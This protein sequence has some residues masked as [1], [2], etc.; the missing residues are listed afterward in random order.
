[1]EYTRSSARKVLI[2]FSASF[3]LFLTFVSAFLL[4]FLY[5]YYV[6]GNAVVAWMDAPLSILIEVLNAVALFSSVAASVYGIRL[7]GFRDSVP[8]VLLNAAQI[9]LSFLCSLAVS[10]LCT[11]PALFAANFLYLLRVVGLNLLIYAAVLALILL[12]A[13]LAAR[14]AGYKGK[15]DL[16]LRGEFFTSRHP[17]L[18]SFHISTAIYVGCALI[19]SIVRTVTDLLEY[20]LPVNQTEWIY[21]ISPY[22]ESAAYYFL[23]YA[24]LV[25]C[26]YFIQKRIRG[27]DGE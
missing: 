11:T 6:Q 12:A 17:L 19:T 22:V 14:A 26:G 7:L 9:L 23:C 18:F 8:L 25:G 24:V 13:W 4:Q 10:F 21:E 5:G 27:K 1:M 15:C 2:R 3:P 20:G 16:T